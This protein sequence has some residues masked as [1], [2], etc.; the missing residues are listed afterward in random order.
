[1]IDT[2]FD[3]EMDFCSKRNTLDAVMD[4]DCF[5]TER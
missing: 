5:N 4:D 3:Y 1:M 2:H